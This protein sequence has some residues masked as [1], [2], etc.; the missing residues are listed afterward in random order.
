[1][2]L[3]KLTIG[4]VFSI[5]LIA[6]CGEA[7]KEKS[8][9]QGKIAL[10]PGQDLMAEYYFVGGIR[11]IAETNLQSLRS[12]AGDRSTPPVMAQFV[13]GLGNLFKIRL[14]GAALT[15]TNDPAFLVTQSLLNDEQMGQFGVGPNNSLNAFIATRPSNPT[16]LRAAFQQLAEKFGATSATGSFNLSI[17]LPNQQNRLLQVEQKAD[18]LLLSVSEPNSPQKARFEQF[19]KARSASAITNYLDLQLDIAAVRKWDADFLAPLKPATLE[20]AMSRKSSGVRTLGR[21]RF[22]GDVNWKSQPWKVPISIITDPLITFTALREVKPFFTSSKW[23]DDI[24]LPVFEKQ[25]FLWAQGEVPFQLGVAIP[26]SNG[27]KQIEKVGKESI[28]KFNPELKKANSGQLAMSPDSAAVIWNGLPYILPNLIATNTTEGEFLVARL[29]PPPVASGPIPKELWDQFYPKKD[30]V[31][32]DWELSSERVGHWTVLHSLI[33]LLNSNGSNNDPRVARRNSRL[34]KWLT[35][36]APL[37]GNTITEVI[38]TEAD[39]LQVLRRSD[40]G[41]TGFELVRLAFYLDHLNDLPA[42]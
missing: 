1:M 23:F 3:S 4:V 32:Y 6:G 12:I 31:L 8:Q 5:L 7:S 22:A 27:K 29:F 16:L 18:W 35:T 36:T 11:L 38:Q 14:L 19:F 25:V 40:L 30:L 33:P 20:L 37:L 26:V 13:S 2:K 24:G 28:A 9:A 34:E 15:G 42:K 17:K 21:L 39:D 10:S 41:F